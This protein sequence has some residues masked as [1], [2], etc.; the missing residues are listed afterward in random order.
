MPV[1]LHY[2]RAAESTVFAQRAIRSPL[3][4][5]RGSKARSWAGMAQKRRG[6]DTWLVPLMVRMLVWSERII[7]FLI[8]VLLFAGAIALLIRA[9]TIGV[10]LFEVHDSE[11]IIV[12]GSGFLDMILLTLM[13]VELAYTVMLSLH[14]EVLLAEPF[15]IVGLIAVIRR[16]LVI[17]IGEVAGNKAPHPQTGVSSSTIELLLLTAVVVAFVVAIFILRQHKR[18]EAIPEDL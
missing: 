8:G 4:K 18:N 3:R 1:S 17:T 10:T 11:S 14:G 13:V 5:A 16:I 6:R 9:A 7:F 12:A 15:L 2:E